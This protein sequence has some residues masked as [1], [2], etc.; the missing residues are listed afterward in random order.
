MAALYLRTPATWFLGGTSCSGQLHHNDTCTCSNHLVWEASHHALKGTQ[1][2]FEHDQRSLLL[3]LTVGSGLSFHAGWHKQACT[4]SSGLYQVKGCVPGHITFQPLNELLLV[5]LLAMQ[6]LHGCRLLSS[7]C[8]CRCL[9][10]NMG[11]R[12]GWAGWHIPAGWHLRG[13]TQQAGKGSQGGA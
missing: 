8:S 9:G 7:I 2:S 5:S 4:H 12:G 1:H 10:C 6:L 3:Q 11:A 13:L